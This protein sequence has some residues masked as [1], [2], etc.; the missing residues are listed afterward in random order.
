LEAEPEK[1]PEEEWGVEDP[2]ITWIEE[3]GK[4]AVVYTAYSKGGPLVSLALTEDFENFEKLGAIMPPEDKD[5]AL[6]PRRINGKWVLIHRPISIH[7]G[8]GAHIWISRSD[9]LKPIFHRSILRQRQKAVEQTAALLQGN[10][11][12]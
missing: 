11:I 5:A 1:F 8:P 12:R 7:H 4:F 10:S 6:F 2:R 9:D 3:L